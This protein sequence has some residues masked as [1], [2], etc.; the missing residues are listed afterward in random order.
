MPPYTTRL[1]SMLEPVTQSPNLLRTVATMAG[2]K[3]TQ[4]QC[5]QVVGVLVLIYIQPYDGFDRER[6]KQECC[7]E[8][9]W[10]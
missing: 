3:Q 10:L 6:K 2:G 7:S 4:H 8:V 5:M 1:A 9:L